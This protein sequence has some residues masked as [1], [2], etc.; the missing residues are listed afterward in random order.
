MDDNFGL[1]LRRFQRHY[2][3]TC[4]Q[5]ARLF[6]VSV[7]TYNNWITGRRVAGS[8]VRRLADVLNTMSFACRDLHAA[9]IR[10]CKTNDRK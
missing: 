7:D 10:E 9:L 1:H 5:A 6:G 8:S 2:G 3:L 4:E